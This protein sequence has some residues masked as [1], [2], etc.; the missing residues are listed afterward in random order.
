MLSR[1]ERP[2]CRLRRRLPLGEGELC[3][4]ILLALSPPAKGEVPPKAARGSLTQPLFPRSPATRS[5]CRPKW[6]GS[7]HKEPDVSWLQES[8][9]LSRRCREPCG[10]SARERLFFQEQSAPRQCRG[11]GFS[12]RGSV[13]SRS[14]L[15]QKKESAAPDRVIFLAILGE[16]ARPRG[17]QSFSQAQLRHLQNVVRPS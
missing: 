15:R 5:S 12:S 10:R 16:S 4:S 3:C 17:H 11:C 1:S 14:D 7:R 9:L 13:S 6:R 2:P 8:L